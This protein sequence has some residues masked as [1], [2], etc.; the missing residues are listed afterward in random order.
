MKKSI[1]ILLVIAFGC[2]DKKEPDVLETKESISIVLPKNTCSFSLISEKKV[3][4]QAGRIGFRDDLNMYYINVYLG[5]IDNTLSGL[6]CNMPDELKT[7]DKQVVF[8]GEYF[9]ASQ[10]P[11][12]KFG[13]ETMRYL[14]LTAIK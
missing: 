7:V 2:D 8:D 4:K 10:L 3:T 5:G 14:V 9:T 12:P 6:V 13:G 11:Y 1:F